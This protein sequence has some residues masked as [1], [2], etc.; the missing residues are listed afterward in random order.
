MAPAMHGS[1][2]FST[3]C[4][5][6]EVLIPFNVWKMVLLISISLTTVM[7][8]IFVS[9]FLFLLFL[10]LII[11]LPIDLYYHLFWHSVF[12][13]F[14]VLVFTY[15]SASYIHNILQYLL[16]YY[17]CLN[18]G[19]LCPSISFRFLPQKRDFLLDS[20]QPLLQLGVCG[21]PGSGCVWVTRFW[22]ILGQCSPFPSSCCLKCKCQV[23]NMRSGSH[24]A[25]PQ[26]TRSLSPHATEP[27]PSINTLTWLLFKPLLFGGV[28]VHLEVNIIL[29]Q[30]MTLNIKW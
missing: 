6:P 29:I 18:R 1:D 22:S 14:L 16:P 12:S 5:A 23:W 10:C 21:W 28:G 20:L 27:R 3:L 19:W 30:I 4:A 17:I 11:L 8:N 15:L 25:D 2:W 26:I 24:T 9:S 13:C 7:F